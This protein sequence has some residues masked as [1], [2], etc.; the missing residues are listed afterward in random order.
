M[1]TPA[2][3]LS[4]AFSFLFLFIG[5]TVVAQEHK[6]AET[7][8][9]GQKTANQT[10]P[11]PNE[12]THPK[13]EVALMLEEASKKGEPIL[14]ACI[15]NC[16]PNLERGHAL[17][18]PKPPYPALARH[19]RAAGRVEVKVIIDVEGNVIAAS[20]VSGHPLLFA[21]SVAAA[22]EARFTTTRYAGK[23]VKVLGIIQYNFVAQ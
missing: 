7:K 2:G 23:P 18:L 3:K 6:P 4:I 16:V 1:N 17:N 5:S 12:P 8:P 9:S 14:T 13:N 22:R 10:V 11:D 15:E 20:A 19:A 21:A